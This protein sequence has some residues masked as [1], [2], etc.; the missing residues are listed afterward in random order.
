MPIFILWEQ[1][2]VLILPYGACRRKQ[3]I[4]IVILQL[5]SDLKAYGK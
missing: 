2:T 3:Q 4:L 1:I 5:E